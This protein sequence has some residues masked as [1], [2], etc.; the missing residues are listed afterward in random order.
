MVQFNLFLIEWRATSESRLV[1]IPSRRGFDRWKN[2]DRR[3]ACIVQMWACGGDSLA[4]AAWEWNGRVALLHSCGWGYVHVSRS[5]VDW[6]KIGIIFEIIISVKGIWIWVIRAI[7]LFYWKKKSIRGQNL[8]F[9][10]MND[11][12]YRLRFHFRQILV[13]FGTIIDRW[14]KDRY[15]C[16]FLMKCTRK[17]QKILKMG[18]EQSF[19]LLRLSATITGRYHE[20]NKHRTPFCSKESLL[21][22]K[23]H[24]IY[25]E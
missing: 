6:R 14:I 3:F 19:F 25:A 20:V 23:K 16:L 15:S 8:M 11:N 1:V 7:I 24:Q 22:P 10:S 5:W 13:S 21:F 4:R 17:M 2:V 18:D 9:F 12:F